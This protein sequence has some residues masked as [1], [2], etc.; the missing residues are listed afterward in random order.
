MPLAGLAIGIGG[1]AA[2]SAGWKSEVPQIPDAATFGFRPDEHERLRVRGPAWHC[3]VAGATH[4]FRAGIS[5]R[6]GLRG[7]RGPVF[8]RSGIPR[9]QVG[10]VSPHRPRRW[11]KWQ[12]AAR[13]VSGARYVVRGFLNVRVGSVG[14]V[15]ADPIGAGCSARAAAARS[16]RSCRAGHSTMSFCRLRHGARSTPPWPG[17]PG[18]TPLLGHQA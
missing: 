10:L 14:G 6:L 4:H 7:R 15:R 8:Y 18:S 12:S 13:I 9:E 5:R 3:R 1:Q 16:S 17:E 11:R 2:E